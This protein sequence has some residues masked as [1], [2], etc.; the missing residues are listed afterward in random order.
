M[1]SVGLHFVLRLLSSLKEDDLT[2]GIGEAVGDYIQT[3]M[4]KP[5]T[6]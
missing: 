4:I 5:S 6:V 1:G 3:V 2:R